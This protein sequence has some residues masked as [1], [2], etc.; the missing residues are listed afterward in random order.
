M[1]ASKVREELLLT[2][3]FSLVKAKEGVNSSNSISIGMEIKCSSFV[4]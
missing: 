4:C 3:A 2:H 1:V